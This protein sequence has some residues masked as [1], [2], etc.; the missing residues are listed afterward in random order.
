MLASTRLRV[1]QRRL[2]S[3]MQSEQLETVG[4]EQNM[5]IY[6]QS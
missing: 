5:Y 4:K 2:V 1:M 3:T 6:I